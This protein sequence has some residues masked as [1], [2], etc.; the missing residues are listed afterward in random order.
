MSKIKGLVID[1][2]SMHAEIYDQ[3]F[4]L[5]SRSMSSE[6][7]HNIVER[8][9]ESS[10]NRWELALSKDLDYLSSIG[11]ITPFIGLFGTV[12]G[13]MNSFQAIA[14]SN[15]TSI[16]IV[17]PGISEALFATALG[18]FVAIPATIAANLFYTKI[19]IFKQDARVFAAFVLDRMEGFK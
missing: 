10:L 1:E 8:I 16:A 4:L 18:L 11:S 17:A 13:I 7:K 12:W 3:L 15:S 5:I 6:E 9:I 2:S 19:D 14:L